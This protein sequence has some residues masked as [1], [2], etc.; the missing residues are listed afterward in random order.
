[1]PII[2][3]DN[4]YFKKVLF[5]VSSPSFYSKY[6][7]LP[8]AS[9]SPP[10]AIRD[11]PKFWPFFD[12][13][14]GAIDGTHVRCCP[15]ASERAA[16]RNRKG[17]TSQ[18]CLACCDWDLRFLYFVSGWEG[19]AAD[20]SMYEASRIR[21]FFIPQGKYYL[22]DA[23]FGICDSLMVPYRGVRYHL[24]EWGRAAVRYIIYFVLSMPIFTDLEILGLPIAKNCS[25]FDMLRPGI[26]LNVFLALSRIV[27]LSLIVPLSLTWKYKPESHQLS[28]QFTT[29]LLA[30]IPKIWRGL[31]IFSEMRHQAATHWEIIQV[32]LQ[33]VQQIVQKRRQQLISEIRLLKRCGTVIRHGLQSIPERI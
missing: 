12:G 16:A 2:S 14:I 25:I 23:G 32:S 7:Y 18:N 17:F 6:V 22:A 21:N 29:T 5:A 11:N 33:M 4:R 20:A 10:S 31:M 24:A 1:M 19:A 26:L 30:K 27:S 8:D 15:S 13:A 28:Q 3:F 9:E